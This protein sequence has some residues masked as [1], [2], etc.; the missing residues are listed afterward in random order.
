[1]LEGEIKSK[2]F[3][4]A[5]SDLMLSSLPFLRNGSIPFCMTNISAQEALSWV[6]QR[7]AGGADGSAHQ[8]ANWLTAVLWGYV[9]LLRLASQ[10]PTSACR[11]GGEGFLGLT[12]NV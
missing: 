3:F 5:A 10:N 8:E 2:A 12:C 11:V 9:Q 4:P 7:A 6:S 1:M